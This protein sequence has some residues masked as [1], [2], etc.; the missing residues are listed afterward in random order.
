MICTDG[1]G[2]FSTTLSNEYMIATKE[3]GMSFEEIFQQSKASIDHIFAGD[4]IKSMLR[5]KW[6]HWRKQHDSYFT[7]K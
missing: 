4:N 1:K 6:D 2:A 5:Q 3:S 7:G